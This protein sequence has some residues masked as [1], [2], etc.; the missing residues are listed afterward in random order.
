LFSLIRAEI[1]ALRRWSKC[2]FPDPKSTQY[3]KA[4]SG[5]LPMRGRSPKYFSTLTEAD[6]RGYWALQDELLQFADHRQR[7]RRL[8]IFADVLSTIRTYA[9]R[10]DADDGARCCVCGVCFLPCGIGINSHQL[11][12]L[13]NRCKSSINGALKLMGYSMLSARGDVNPDLVSALPLLRGRMHDLRL[14]SVRAP[15]DE[16][17]DDGCRSETKIDDCDLSLFSLFGDH[18]Q[19]FEPFG[20]DADGPS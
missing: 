19:P 17:K 11:R 7:G 9:Q 6:R 15:P 14:W 3:L 2:Q 8:S 20:Y 12:H 4:T 1:T 18:S 13:T 16:T 5:Q 10:G